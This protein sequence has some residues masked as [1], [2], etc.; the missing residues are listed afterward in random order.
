MARGSQHS[1]IRT[2]DVVWHSHQ[3]LA[4]AVIEHNGLNENGGP[5][6]WSWKVYCD[7]E[8]EGQSIYQN[9][10]ARATRPMSTAL[11]DVTWDAPPGEGA[12]AG[13]GAA[14]ADSLTVGVVAAPVSVTV[15]SVAGAGT[16]APVS[17]ALP[18]IPSV[19]VTASIPVPMSVPVLVAAHT[20][21]G[22]CT[23][24]TLLSAWCAAAVL[25][26]VR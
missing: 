25:C 5:G 19:L 20:N 26:D 11:T 2:G 24:N 21:A 4:D 6:P 9:S 8:W 1:Y 10:S 16:V 23:S 7:N 15:V 18:P 17:V 3:V 12:G 13:A 14:A 22:A